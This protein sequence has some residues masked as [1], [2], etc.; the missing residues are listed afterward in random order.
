MKL[1]CKDGGAKKYKNQSINQSIEEAA[2]PPE[3]CFQCP[4]CIP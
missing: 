2:P 1:L 4:C 3:Y